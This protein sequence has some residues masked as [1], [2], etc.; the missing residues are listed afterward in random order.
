MTATSHDGAAGSASALGR[1]GYRTGR[2]LGHAQLFVER[3]PPWLVLG[4]LVLA[5]WG[6][7]AEIARIAS[8][9]GP[10]YYTGGDSNWYYTSSWQLA[11]GRIPYASISYGFPL[12]TA[13]IALIA[14]P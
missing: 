8:H 11:N 2:A 12:V 10:V 5:D 9:N 6:V 1:A 4:L 7:T 13:P 3:L 14:G